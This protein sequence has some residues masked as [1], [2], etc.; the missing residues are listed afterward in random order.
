MAENKHLIPVETTRALAR[1]G[2]QFGLVN[3]VLEEKLIEQRLSFEPE[4]IFVQGGTFQMGSDD[5]NA[6]ENEKPVHTVTL[7]SFYISKYPVTQKQ[8]RHIMGYN[9]SNFE[10]CNYCPVGSVSWY[11]AQ[12]FLQKLNDKTGKK[13]R[14]PT[15]AEW[16]F[17]ARGGIKSK[18]YKYSGSNDLNEVAWYIQ[19]SDRKSHPVGQKKPNELGIYDMSG[20]VGEFCNDF[21]NENYYKKSPL[22]NPQGPEE[23]NERVI[24]GGSWADD[25]D[26]LRVSYR[27]DFEPFSDDPC[28]GEPFSDIGFRVMF[29]YD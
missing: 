3:K 7:D 25:F 29:R 19:D 18:N 14:L 11:D 2:V 15:E 5:E 12:E 16:E 23:G 4:M 21:Y 6:H 20:N 1:I 24:R 9:P 10:D 17:A 13:Y 28:V 22:L 8:W 26:I 27:Y